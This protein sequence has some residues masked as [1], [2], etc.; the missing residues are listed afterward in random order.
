MGLLHPG[1]FKSLGSRQSTLALTRSKNGKSYTSSGHS[2][3]DGDV[4]FKGRR[5]LFAHNVWKKWRSNHAKFRGAGCHGFP[6][7]Y[8]KPPVADICSPCY[9]RIDELLIGPKISDICKQDYDCYWLRYF[10]LSTLIGIKQTESVTGNKR[11]HHW[12]ANDYVKSLN[13]WFT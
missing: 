10:G 1:T 6:A 9:E 13:A 11:L 2:N 12:D 3:W 5:P 8:E 4:T 7:I